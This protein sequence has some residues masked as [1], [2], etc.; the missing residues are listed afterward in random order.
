MFIYLYTWTPIHNT[1]LCL[2]TCCHSFLWKDSIVHT[3]PIMLPSNS[4]GRKNCQEKKGEI[5][6]EIVSQK[7]LRSIHKKT[8]KHSMLV[9]PEFWSSRIRWVLCTHVHHCRHYIMIIFGNCTVVNC[10]ILRLS[11][12]RVCC[13]NLSTWQLH[14]NHDCSC[15]QVY[16]DVVKFWSYAH[17]E[18]QTQFKIWGY[19]LQ[20]GVKIVGLLSNL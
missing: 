20:G 7:C 5:L 19:F 3:H 9:L 15:S 11:T 14:S 16:N 8:T 4:R 1:I 17:I 6:W 18:S 13:V 10:R 2:C 12:N